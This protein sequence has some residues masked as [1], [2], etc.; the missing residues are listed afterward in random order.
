MHRLSGMRG[1]GKRVEFFTKESEEIN[2]QSFDG[3]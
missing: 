1:V 3:V 2:I